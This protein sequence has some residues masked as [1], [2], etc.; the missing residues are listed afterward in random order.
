MESFGKTDDLLQDILD[1]G[2]YGK[3]S[4]SRI[5]SSNMTLEAASDEKH[6]SGLKKTL[7]PSMSYMK[8][9]YSYVEKYPFLLPVAWIMRIFS[10][11]RQTNRKE[12]AE[13]IKIGKRRV[14][15]IHT[16][17]LS[18]EKV[19]NTN[20]YLLVI[21]ELIQEGKEVRIPISGGSMTPFLVPKRDDVF[22]KKPEQKPK[23][24]DIVLYQRQSGQFVL[25]RICAAHKES[26]DIIGD[27]QTEIEKNVHATQIFGVV[28]KAAR[29]GKIIGKKN[30]WWLF[31]E[32][33]WIRM[34]PV[35]P[36]AMKIYTLLFF[37]LFHNM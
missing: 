24:G 32:K 23:V 15:L 16:Y 12:I 28:Y 35:R 13:T 11:I 19:V 27:A 6:S 31:F 29:K 18:G 36:I 8:K 30:F 14:K 3:S 1:S 34:I 7:F 25:H 2:V 26:Y 5:H 33:V 10:Y 4:V 17:G 9:S 21:K 20:A 22:I 37:K